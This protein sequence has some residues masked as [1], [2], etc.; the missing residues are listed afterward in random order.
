M[1]SEFLAYEESDNVADELRKFLKFRLDYAK[2]NK[3]FF[4]LAISRS[5]LDPTIREDLQGYARMK[6]LALIE[7]F[8]RIRDK[9]GMR[10]DI[11]IDKF[12]NAH[13]FAFAVNILSL[14][15][16]CLEISEAEGLIEAAVDIFTRG[17]NPK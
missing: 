4:K 14:A 7:R 17:V 5:I 13:S 9:G 15:I 3:K 6:P 8:E 10:Q 16:E 12:I 1:I 11:D 2:R